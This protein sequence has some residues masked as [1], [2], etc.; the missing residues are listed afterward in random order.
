M[1]LR[2]RDGVIERLGRWELEV[3]ELKGKVSPRWEGWWRRVGR[4]IAWVT[5]GRF[6]AEKKVDGL[7]REMEDLWREYELYCGLTKEP[8]GYVVLLTSVLNFFYSLTGLRAHP[9]KT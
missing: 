3:Q 1:S 8:K 2:A 5:Y 4:T 9:L 7:G 6:R